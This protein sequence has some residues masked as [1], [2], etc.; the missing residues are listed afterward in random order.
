[1]GHE[2]GQRWVMRVGG[3]IIFIRMCINHTQ[4]SSALRVCYIVYSH[5]CTMYMYMYSLR[6]IA[7]IP[8]KCTK[9]VTVRTSTI[10]WEHSMSTRDC[11][12]CLASS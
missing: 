11:W 10:S 1:M 6:I 4:H 3:K 8:W 7:K 5:L 9:S 12:W 2:G